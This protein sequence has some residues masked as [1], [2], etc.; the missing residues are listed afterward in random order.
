MD[1]IRQLQQKIAQM[2]Q[3]WSSLRLKIE[4]DIKSISASG[5]GAGR[6]VEL[7]FPTKTVTSDYT[8]NRHDYYVGV[9]S[10]DLVKI[11]LPS[12]S[13]PGRQLVIKDESGTA[14]LNH[15]DVIGIIDNDS[16]GVSIRIN[17]GSITLIYNNGWRII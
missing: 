3:F 1:E 14:Q 5:G 11:Y 12:T 8:I 2:E 17:N 6:V 4:K 9:N 7:D 13:F 10:T 16:D 15:I